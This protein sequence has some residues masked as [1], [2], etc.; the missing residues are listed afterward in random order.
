MALTFL[1]AEK[2]V[3]RNGWSDDVLSTVHRYIEI[4]KKYKISNEAV[5]KPAVLRKIKRAKLNNVEFAVFVLTWKRLC[6]TKLLTAFSTQSAKPCQTLRDKG[7][8]FVESQRSNGPEFLVRKGGEMYRMATA[9]RPVSYKTDLVKA[10]KQMVAEYRQ[11]KRCPYTGISDRLELDHRTPVSACKKLGIKP[12]R[13]TDLAIRNGTA[14]Q[15]F[16]W[17]STNMNAQKREACAKCQAGQRI[18]LPSIVQHSRFKKKWS[19]K[20]C[21]GCFYYD[22]LNR[23]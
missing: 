17:I 22:P 1:E 5:L 23:K 11:N 2:L 19:G 8:V 9:F 12:A 20:G 15:D 16:Q 10:S 14:D 13:L 6:S 21:R 7:V 3:E 4:C 18:P